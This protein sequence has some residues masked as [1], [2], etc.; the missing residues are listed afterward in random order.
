[1]PAPKRNLGRGLSALIPPKPA[2]S[3]E[4]NPPSAPEAR[5]GLS[6]IPIDEV[7]PSDAQPRQVFDDAYL[8]ELAG[9]IRDHGILQPIVVRRRSPSQYEIVAGERRWRASQRAGLRVIPAVIADVAEQDML[10]LALVENVQRQDLNP[11]EEAEA[12][13]RLN[14]ELG[15][16][17]SEIAKAVG[18]DRTTIANALRLLKLPQSV[19]S[20]VLD[21]RLTMGHARSLLAL[22]TEDA[23]Q[24][25][26]KEIESKGL[27][28]RQTEALVNT[29]KPG[30]KAS[31]PVV[32]P[33]KKRGASESDAE[34][35]VRLRVQRA[36]ATKV[37]LHQKEGA[38]TLTLHFANFD[39]LDRL[40]EAMGA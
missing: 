34:R 14:T 21:G 12:F 22:P 17:Q 33:K 11:I 3:S 19:Q 6:Q 16:S 29:R 26:A 8:E 1:M 27:S 18:K 5:N 4:S 23:I 7:L 35:D 38:G 28:V 37:E 31:A 15:Y 25:T 32:K 30:A 36:L 24:T 40:L 20:Q 39:E 10:T 9:S 13:Q 2:Q